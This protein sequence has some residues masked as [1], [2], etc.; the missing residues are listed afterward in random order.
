MTYTDSKKGSSFAAESE[1]IIEVGGQKKEEDAGSIKGEEG[2][3]M[4]I[5]TLTEMDDDQ[6]AKDS[7]EPNTCI[8]KEFGKVPVTEEAKESCV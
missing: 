5:I 4:K 8:I 2:L 3:E 6:K 7:E 1:A